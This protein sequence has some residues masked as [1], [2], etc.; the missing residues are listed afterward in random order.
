MEAMAEPLELSVGTAVLSNF[1]DG[2]R[3]VAVRDKLAGETAVLVMSTGPPV[4][5]NWICLALFCDACRRAGASRIVVV[6]PYMG[7]ARGD[8]VSHPG[9]PAAARLV[10]DLLQ[11]S[12]ATHLVVLD[13]HNPA[14]VG[15][16][17]IPVVEV[18]AVELLA[19]RFRGCARDCT[20]VAPDA[21]AVKRASAFAAFLRL[22]L[23]IALKRR[24]AP[25]EPKVIAIA[26]ELS[27][28]DVIVVDDLVST[29]KTLA[30]VVT[31]L[32]DAGA[33]AVDLAATHAVMC[34]GAEG[35]LRAVEPRRLVVTDSLAFVPSAPWPVLDVVPVAGLLAPAVDRLLG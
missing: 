11:L 7:Y 21:G 15:C 20:V 22:P 25:D 10:A 35:R 23:A 24:P 34:P 13:W 1:A 9:E 6:M 27:G 16:F 29:G 5:S 2:E 31:A 28:R 17:L 18:S 14:L 30:Q 3:Q 32:R 33:R 19:R 12:G 26:G 8:R 4:D